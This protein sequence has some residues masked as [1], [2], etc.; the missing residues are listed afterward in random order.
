MDPAVPAEAT[1]RQIAADRHSGAMADR[2][3]E[4]ELLQLE[5]ELV[6]GHPG[7]AVAR[8][9][10]PSTFTS[11]IRERSSSRVPSRRWLPAQL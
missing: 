2:E 5:V 9:F 1:L 11:R 3:E 6:A 4:A 7:W 8:M 10:S